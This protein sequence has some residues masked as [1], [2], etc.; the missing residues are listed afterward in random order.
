M[1]KKICLLL[2]MGLLFLS[3][4]QSEEIPPE[5]E[6]VV[7]LQESHENKK[8]TDKDALIWPDLLDPIEME[9]N[10]AVPDLVRGSLE[11]LTDPKYQ[12][13]VVGSSGNR[14]A[15]DWIEEQFIQLGLQQYPDLGGWRHTWEGDIYEGTASGES[16]IVAPDGSEQALTYGEDWLS[17]SSFEDLDVTLPLTEDIKLSASGEAFLDENLVKQGHTRE[18]MGV[19]SGDLHEG[20]PVYNSG[21]SPVRIKVRQEI[22]ELLKQKGYQLRVKIPQTASVGTI[23][24]IVAYLPG[25]DHSKVIV[26]GAHFDGSGQN[27]PYLNPSAFDNASGAAAL[28]QTAACLAGAEQLACD[29][30]FVAFNSEENGLHG[31]EA[32]AQY[33]K[34]QYEQTLMIN[35]DCVGWKG[36]QTVIYGAESPVFC[37]KLSNALGYP[38]YDQLVYSGDQQSF[39]RC[40]MD[41]LTIS[42]E[43][44]EADEVQNILHSTGDQLG[45][46][47]PDLIYDLSTELAVWILE[48]GDL[49]LD[50]HFVYW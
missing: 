41:A 3:A 40:Q 1:K 22:Y 33:W 47:D 44:M 12:G 28:L 8:E 24:N 23:D 48:R 14:A 26:L 37:R 7:P 21:H 39:I 36:S 50:T 6:V 19:R 11:E 15:A 42:Q 30:V 13:R 16:W 2:A 20:W 18:S 35:I 4:C 25:E 38:Y 31:S 17:S 49:P 27:G 34:G 5:E 32:F 46:L 43:I 29:V 10:W 45:L 9:R